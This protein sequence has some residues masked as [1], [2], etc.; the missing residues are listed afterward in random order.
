M[1]EIIK[2][3]PLSRAR[4]G[5]LTVGKSV[6]ETPSYV[7]VGTNAEVRTLEPEDLV[8]TKT[9]M[10]I[11]NTYHLWRDLG[12]EGLTNF[13]GLREEL[14]FNGVIM[15]DSGGFQVFSYGFL[16]ENGMRLGPK[17]REAKL[18]RV[19]EAEGGET[20]VLGRNLV[21]ITPSGVYFQPDGEGDE[22][23]YLDAELSVKIQEQLGAD[24][25]V[26]FDEPTSPAADYEYTKAAMERTHAWAQR[27]QDA[28][29]SDQKMYGVV[30]GGAYE[31]LRR[32]S[33]EF[34][35]NLGFDGFA[36]GST[37]G[38][39]YGGTK[40]KTKDMLDWSIPFLPERKPRH[41]FGIGRI[42]DLFAGVEAGIDTF[43][44]VIPTREARHGRLWT[45]QGYI[46]IKKGKF[47]KDDS[48]VEEGCECPTCIDGMRRFEL[49]HLFRD[50]NP[51]AGRR[52][53]MHNVYFFNDLMEQIRNSI[54]E[55]AFQNFK[56]EY[57]KN[58]TKEK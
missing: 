27:S 46:D 22:E 56:K 1:F 30:Q 25:I 53:T 36:I 43:D 17:E 50:K 38:D 51:E 58:L 57:L 9:Q 15:T 11:S 47:A 41:L 19:G 18:V 24:I 52:A 5:R 21:R 20:A 48:P 23:Q 34:I 31:D 12:E 10:I 44:C 26:A 37:Y 2:T 3:D 28:R 33:S 6:V 45:A 54:R 55:G 8:A 42:E 7:I 14:G 32:A 39:S 40:Q 16:R 13:P 4:V 35:G 49:H 29:Q